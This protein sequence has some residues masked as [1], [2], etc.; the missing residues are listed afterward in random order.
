M[1]AA[2][3]IEVLPK[4]VAELLEQLKKADGEINTDMFND[5]DPKLLH[6]VY[7]GMFENS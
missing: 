6:K 5:V 3:G 4:A 1:P 7:W 2:K